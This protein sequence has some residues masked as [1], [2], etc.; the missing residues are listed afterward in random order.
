MGKK[1]LK[2][3]V[4]RMMLDTSQ[5]FRRPRAQKGPVS[6][7]AFP[8]PSPV[9]PVPRLCAH[10]PAPWPPAAAGTGCSSGSSRGTQRL[11][12]GAAP[13]V[14]S[15]LK[16]TPAPPGGGSRKR[17][18]RGL[19]GVAGEAGSRRWESDL[20][21]QGR[22]D[23]SSHSQSL[24]PAPRSSRRERSGEAR[25]PGTAGHRGPLGTRRAGGGE[26]RPGRAQVSAAVPPPPGRALLP[27]PRQPRWVREPP[28]RPPRP[29][30]GPRHPNPNLC[31]QHPRSS[32]RLLPSPC[33]GVS[34]FP[35]FSP[36]LFSAPRKSLAPAGGPAPPL[37]LREAEPERPAR[38]EQGRRR[39][40]GAPLGGLAPRR[41]AALRGEEAPL[42]PARAPTRGVTRRRPRPP[43]RS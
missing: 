29:Q 35:P 26:G 17:G 41:P 21:G 4:W 24:L 11:A 43:A 27:P 9:R 13:Q 25:S 38:G 14:H 1:D 10:H 18:A 30:G 31:V 20:G 2:K 28:A 12:A 16:D 8:F 42:S 5:Y 7:P 15:G 36:R 37:T 40:R 6:D 22:A 19:W 34:L 32:I 23:P 3:R 33:L 39:E